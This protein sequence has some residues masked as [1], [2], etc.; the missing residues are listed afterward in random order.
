[1]LSSREQ[2]AAPTCGTCD[3]ALSR[4]FV[5]SQCSYAGCWSDGHVVTHLKESAH[6]FCKSPPHFLFCWTRHLLRWTGVDVKSGSV[7][8]S[9]CNNFIYHSKLDALYLA[10]IVAA[11]EKQMGVYLLLFL[12]HRSD[13]LQLLI[14]NRS[15]HGAQVRRRSKLLRVRSRLRVRVSCYSLIGFQYSYRLL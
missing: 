12:T 4:P 1:M 10:T 3:I 2:I 14:K 7:Y 13:T 8:C 5:C 11:E 6:L 9:E 15:N